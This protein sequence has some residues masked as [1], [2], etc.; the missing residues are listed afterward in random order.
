[1]STRSLALWRPIAEAARRKAARFDLH[2]LPA[3]LDRIGSLELRLATS[4]KEVRRA[5]R[6]RYKVFSKEGGATPD[7]TARLLRRDVCR[8]D[9]ICDHLIVVDLAARRR[10]GVIKPRVVGVYRLLRQEIAQAQ[11]G[12]YSAQEF[13]LSPMLAARKGDRILELGRSCVHRDYRD[14]KVLELL[15]RGLWI[16]ARH[17]RIDAMIG[18]ASLPG[19]DAQRHAGALAFLRDCA[20]AREDF[21]A[22]P[23]AH[24]RAAIETD[25]AEP[26]SFR[27]ALAALPP[28][29]KG[30]LRVGARFG[31]GAVV[32]RQFN[33]TDVFVVVRMCDIDT[34]YIEHIVGERARAA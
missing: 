16:Y 10:T 12:F 29:I 23:L 33:C 34:R 31:E 27:R 14:R 8:Y 22:A 5:Q 24:R 19:V 2:G 6:L 7:P 26:L 1:M 20:P 30:Y 13:D 3:V 28:L 32:D 15:W 18:C 17:H 4:K 9:R 25:G 21:N 11:F